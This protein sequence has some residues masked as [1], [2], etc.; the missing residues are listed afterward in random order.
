MA[1]GADADSRADFL[2][3]I[4]RPRVPLKPE[5]A[6]T[7]SGNGVNEYHFIYFTEAGER[8]PGIL[9]KPANVMGRFPVVIALHGTGGSKEGELPFLRQVV[10]KGFIG[11][12][13]DGRY[14]GERSKTGKGSV[15][16]VDAILRAWHEQKEHPFFFDTVWDVMH[17]S[18]I[19]KPVTMWMP[20]VSVSTASPKV[21]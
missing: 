2:K 14:H 15:E 12:A 10:A 4:D 16:Y 6:K 1:R 5:V 13:I 19:W 9:L 11:V 20:T 3:L 21:A 7:A 18:I 8:V 17:S